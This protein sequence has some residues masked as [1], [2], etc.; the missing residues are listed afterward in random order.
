M[1]LS[2]QPAEFQTLLQTV[3]ALLGKQWSALPSS[4][5]PDMGIPCYLHLAGADGARLYLNGETGLT[6]LRVSGGYENHATSLAAR[7]DLNLTIHMSASKTPAQITADIT[8][9]LL[10]DL[11]THV[12]A[13]KAKLAE[14]NA[15][16]ALTVDTAGRLAALVKARV[17]GREGGER[18]L[19]VQDAGTLRAN[20]DRV[21]FERFTIAADEAAAMLSALVRFRK[22]G[23]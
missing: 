8:R 19:W 22:A 4:R 13:C 23:K 9:R 3:A 20:G 15:Y 12:A 1:T 16:E 6:R 11:A 17:D 21:T 10:P 18:S 2:I 7:D 14:A 5:N